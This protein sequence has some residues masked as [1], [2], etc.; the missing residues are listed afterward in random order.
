MSD[1]E[2]ELDISFLLDI[3]LPVDN[4]AAHLELISSNFI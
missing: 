1:V 4:K 2:V 3:S